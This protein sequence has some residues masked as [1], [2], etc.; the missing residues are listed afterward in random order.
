MALIILIGGLLLAYL[1]GYFT[2]K[3]S[4]YG[5]NFKDNNK[6]VVKNN[7]K[8]LVFSLCICAIGWV[9]SSFMWYLS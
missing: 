7:N 1:Q 9:Y 5:E 2:Q 3:E 8:L 6:Q 4:H